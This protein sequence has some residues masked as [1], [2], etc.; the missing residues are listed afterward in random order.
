M[1]QM[2][3]PEWKS[4]TQG[5]SLPFSIHYSLSLHHHTHQSLLRHDHLLRLFAF[6]IFFHGFG[7]QRRRFDLFFTCLDRDDDPVAHLA[8]DLNRNLD[9]VLLYSFFIYF[10]PQLLMDRIWL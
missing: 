3:A 7:G 10:W 9:R 4:S 2:K 1:L 6:Q 8:I 5:P